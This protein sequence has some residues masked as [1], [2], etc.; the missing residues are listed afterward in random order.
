MFFYNIQGIRTFAALSVVVF[1]LPFNGSIGSYGVDLFFIISGFLM[2]FIAHNDPRRF[3]IKRIIRIV[4]LYWTATI[5]V[6]LISLWFPTLLQSTTPNFVY[7]LKSMLFV[8]YMKESGIMEPVLFLGWTLNYEMYF[9]II[10]ALCLRLTKKYSSCL[11]AA[12]ISIP[13]L[14]GLLVSLES[15]IFSFYSNSIVLEFIFGIFI[16][17]FW[18]R[19]IGRR[20]HVLTEPLLLYGLVLI[21]A[22]SLPVLQHF[23]DY[24]RMDRIVALG[25]PGFI[26]VLSCVLLEG[27]IKLPKI[28]TRLGNASYSLYIIHPYIIQGF[29]K[30]LVK[31]D[32]F[33]IVTFMWCLV[34]VFASL[35]LALLSYS[36]YEKPAI[37]L[38]RGQFLK[39]KRS[40]RE[41]VLHPTSLASAPLH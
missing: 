7:L 22:L 9:Y 8:P 31:I 4:P 27:G 12:L 11:T 41:P 38:L 35:A 40:V 6:F 36:L 17:Y 2:S 15:D 29:D 25:V 24:I 1:H 14:M 28:F 26:L 21:S 39:R 37:D 34:V 23:S 33:S 18:T 16:Y 20:I 30:V 3:L 13:P 19:K 32:E 10:F 5:G